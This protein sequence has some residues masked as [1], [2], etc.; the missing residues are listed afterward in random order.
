[1]MLLHGEVYNLVERTRQTDFHIKRR[2]GRLKMRDE[3]STLVLNFQNKL[4]QFNLFL[5]E[6]T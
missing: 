3:E 2:G 5:P 1:L 6:L 4:F